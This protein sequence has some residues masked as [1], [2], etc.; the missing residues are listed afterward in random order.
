MG[1][2]KVAFNFIVVRGGKFAK[3]LLCTKPQKAATK[4]TGLKY[5]PEKK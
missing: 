3:S 2:Q 1:L 4:T 5:A